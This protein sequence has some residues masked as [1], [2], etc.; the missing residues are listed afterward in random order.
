MK[1]INFPKEQNL[2]TSLFNRS[3]FD[4]GIQKIVE[5]I[6][7]DIR[8]NGDDALIKYAK[9][10]DNV[11]LD[12][13]SLECSKEEIANAHNLISPKLKKAIDL[14]HKNILEF[15]KKRLP[16]KWSFSPRNGVELGETFQPLERIACYIPGGTAPLISS[17]L[18]TAT[19]AQVAGVKEIVLTTCP[20]K[21][22]TINPAI[23]YASKVV[24]ATQVLK[25]SGVYAIGALAFGTPSLK[26][27]QKIVGPGN[28]YVTA[29]KRAV[30]GYCS[31]DL[32]AGPSEIMII[33]DKKANPKFIAADLLSQAEHGSGFEQAVVISNNKE[34]LE[35][36]IKQVNRQKKQLSRINCIEKVLQNGVFLIHTQDM[37]QACQIAN[38]YAPEHLEIMTQKPQ[39]IARD[40]K[41]A[42]AIFLGQWTPEAVGDFVAGPSHVLPTGGSAKFFNGLTVE[43]FFRRTSLIQYDEQALKSQVDAISQIA[44]AEG[45][46]AHSKSATIRFD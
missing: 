29:A 4:S 34:V 3:A 22:G 14:A 25:L 30:Y 12:L 23:L 16:K 37:K 8:Q 44:L 11:T 6:I 35:Q 33:A 24:G 26:K 17:V 13:S 36:V 27:V 41:S 10:I 38:D 15:S 46:Q 40:I 39:K 7:Q 5:K 19:L 1:I 45:L 31:L 9:E 42:G 32:V 28:A 2:I 20:N 18:H 43:H 21:D